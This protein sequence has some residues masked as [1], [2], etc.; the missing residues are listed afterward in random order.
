MIDNKIRRAFSDAALQY[1]VLADLQNEIGRELS[2][3]LIKRDDCEAILD[4]GMGTGRLTNRLKFY[5]PDAQIV[6][7]D[8]APGMVECAR[9]KYEG[10][11]IVQADARHLA[12]KKEIFDAVVSNLMYQWIEDLPSAFR[13]TY[14]VLKPGGEFHMTMFARRTLQELLE[15]WEASGE[16]KGSIRKLATENDVAKA[17]SLAG[18]QS[19][20]TKSEIIKTHFEDFR[21][22]MEWLKKIGAQHRPKDFFV[23]KERFLKAQE[24]YQ[25]KFKD[26]WGITAS[27][28][29]VWAK[30]KKS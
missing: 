12:F 3:Q 15:S 26:R 16:E 11:S 30:G 14:S 5:F 17:L 20:E 4:I 2:Q 7:L 19:I 10:L 28:E 18:F 22:L 23:G 29:V 13:Q 8:F 6:G 1:E 21:S 24:Y 25:Q 27:F 9:Q